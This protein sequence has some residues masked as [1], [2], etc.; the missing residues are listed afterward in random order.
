MGLRNAYLHFFT[1]L[2]IYRVLGV[3]GGKRF[4]MKL[5]QES[6]NNPPPPPLP[7]FPH[8]SIWK[9][10]ILGFFWGF[11]PTKKALM[12][13]IICKQVCEPLLLLNVTV[14]ILQMLLLRKM[15]PTTNLHASSP[16]IPSWSRPPRM[17]GL[18]VLERVWL[19]PCQAVLTEKS[20]PR[21][22]STKWP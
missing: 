12:S 16:L 6:D 14:T 3:E 18:A 8:K 4:S 10:M 1:W 20:R 9:D 19:W 21:T 7:P 22:C 2:G 11:P 13:C 15:R 17:R 5:G